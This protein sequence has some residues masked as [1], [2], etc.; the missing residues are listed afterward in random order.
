VQHNFLFSILFRLCIHTIFSYL[1]VACVPNVYSIIYE[2]S[3]MPLLYFL[4]FLSFVCDDMNR[5]CRRGLNVRCQIR[6][7]QQMFRNTN[8]KIEFIDPALVEN[9]F[10]P[11]PPLETVPF[12]ID[13]AVNFKHLIQ[14]VSHSYRKITVLYLQHKFLYSWL[15]H[16]KYLTYAVEKNV[17]D[18]SFH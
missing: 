4:P 7:E 2:Q 3:H 17:M 5:A 12:I 1:N 14:F 9:I 6:D 16:T 13:I 8:I 18:S 11:S 10:I 15:L